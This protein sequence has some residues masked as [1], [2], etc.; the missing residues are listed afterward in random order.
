MDSVSPHHKN[1][2]K[3]K[4]LNYET[5]AYYIISY[6]YYFDDFPEI[7]T[8]RCQFPYIVHGMGQIILDW[9]LRHN[10]EIVTMYGSLSEEELA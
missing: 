1:L 4:R 5:R 6:C 3:N 7:T 8:K 2:K 9:K 10:T